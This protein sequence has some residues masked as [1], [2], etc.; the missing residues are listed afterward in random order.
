MAKIRYIKDKEG[1]IVFPVTH[2]RA[3]KGAGGVLLS[4]TLAAIKAGL[5]ASTGFVSMTLS[6]FTE[7]LLNDTLDRHRW[8]FVYGDGSNDLL[9]IYLGNIQAASYKDYSDKITFGEQV[10]TAYDLAVDEGFEGN[11][12]QW[13]ESLKGDPGMN[14]AETVIVEEL[15][16]FP[17]A[18]TMNKVYW[19]EDEEEEGVYAQYI[20][21]FDGQNYTWVQMGT[22]AIDLSDYVRKDSEVW[23]TPEEFDALEVKDATKT[24]NIYEIVSGE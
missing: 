23:L 15:P 24:Y 20:T 12:Q 14:N 16:E 5:T 9:Y 21:Q 19:V 17:S 8:Y 11:L 22:T 4:D 6:E 2:E 10:K 13:L 1:S 18:S 3:V 7:A